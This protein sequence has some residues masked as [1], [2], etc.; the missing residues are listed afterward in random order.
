MATRNRKSRKL[1]GSR[2]VGCGRVGQHRKSG[3]RGGKGKAGLHK[4]KWTWT[5]KY[6]KDHFKKDDF[7][8]PN[9][10]I[11]KRWI[12]L[13]QLEEIA[14]TLNKTE[15]DLSELGYDKLLGKGNITRAYK[16]LVNNCS[17]KAK[18]KIEKIG[19]EVII[20]GV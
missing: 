6:A 3:S 19:G 10:K 5:V 9:R 14:K 2:T 15:I 7:K 12:N 20:K 18:E 17:S 16:V 4:H 11:I 13:D 8:P 1:R